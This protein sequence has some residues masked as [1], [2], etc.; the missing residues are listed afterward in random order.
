MGTG[1]RNI[2][3]ELQGQ[4]VNRLQ[5]QHRVG[6]STAEPNGM[7]IRGF[8]E[9]DGNGG[10]AGVGEKA[11]YGLAGAMHTLGWPPENAK[12]PAKARST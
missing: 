11:S 6:G 9:S 8:Y 5:Q 12:D 1:E 7:K 3:S 4:E 2:L 10:L